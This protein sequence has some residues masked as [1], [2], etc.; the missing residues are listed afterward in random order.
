MTN[1]GLTDR[2]TVRTTLRVIGAF[3]FLVGV[4]GVV[5]GAVVFARG[6]LADDLDSMG[7]DA[8]VGV[9]VFG[10]SGVV[11]VAGVSALSAG[12]LRDQT[13]YVA[14]ETLPVA[15]DSLSFLRDGDGILGVG[16]ADDGRP[17]E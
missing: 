10:V 6:F 2:S 16:P 13:R 15:G 4:A 9:I 14:T 3:L 11:A 12:F 1:H 7:R 5:A 8:L 17:V